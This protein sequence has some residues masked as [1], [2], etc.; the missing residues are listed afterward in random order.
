MITYL[1]YR[2]CEY[3]KSKNTDIAWQRNRALIAT[4]AILVSNSI[5]I[6]FFI[7]SFFYKEQNLL[8]TILSGR[9]FVDKFVI[10]PIL[11][12]PIFLIVYYLGRKNLDAKIELYENESINEKKKKG[13]LVVIYIVLSFLLFT[14]SFFSPLL[15]K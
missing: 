1:Y 8:N 13:I 12:S 7:N 9:H 10:L 15:I 2:V 6:L 14:F 5:T 3:Y 4:S 11:V